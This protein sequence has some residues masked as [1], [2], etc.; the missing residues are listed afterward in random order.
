MMRGTGRGREKEGEGGRGLESLSERG[1]EREKGSQELLKPGSRRNQEKEKEQSQDEK[2]KVEKGSVRGG[3]KYR[4]R[5][6]RVSKLLHQVFKSYYK[7]SSGSKLG[8]FQFSS[9]RILLRFTI[10]E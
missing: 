8:K 2:E 1:R 4:M 9:S 3:E 5:I 6:I 7:L 10:L